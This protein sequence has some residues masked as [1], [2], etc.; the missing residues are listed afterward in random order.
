VNRVGPLLVAG[1]FLVAACQGARK[2]AFEVVL[3]PADAGP[4]GPDV[5][6]DP[7]RPEA[8]E[9]PPPD[10]SLDAPAEANPPANC[11]RRTAVTEDV[12]QNTA[13]ACGIYELTKKVWVHAGATLTIEAGSTIVADPIAADLP[14]LFVARGA[15]LIA[16]GTSR[17][18][19]VFTSGKPAG[20]RMPGDWA[21]VVLFGA[22]AI[23]SGSTCPG[24]AAG[25]RETALAGF[26]ASEA[27][28]Y[29]GGQDDAGS[30]GELEFVRIEFAGG[31]VSPG[32]FLNALT[33]AGC[34][35][36]TRISH[37][38]IH[39]GRDDGIE[40]LGGT[41]GLDHVVVS[42]VAD[43]ALDWNMGWRGTAQF[44]VVHHH[45]P[46]SD[47]AFEGSN[48]INDESAEPRSAPKIANV[49]M[50]S[51]ISNGGGNRALTFKEG[52]RGKL[53]NMVIQGF[54]RDVV[55]FVSAATNLTAEWP[56]NLSI[57][58]SFFWNNGPYLNDPMGDDDMSFPDQ[59]AVEDPARKN[60]NDV[61][62][63]IVITD[64]TTP[65]FVPSN[66]S[67]GNVPAPDFG[68]TTAA[69]AGAFRPR[70]PSPWTAGWTAYP[71]N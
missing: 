12:A 36:A 62:P 11:A 21:G 61:D 43:D 56:A 7:P 40:M 46:R 15:R 6:N 52:T 4:A 27:R 26:P 66:E 59:M 29:F 49:T 35:A 24:G 2:H 5:A 32:T 58:R 19:I 31:E 8:S 51:T 41:A 25:C 70:D 17:Q 64:P 67:L 69:F 20:A 18:P 55:N 9:P 22:A 44:L 23:N 33:V 57:E 16:R 34:G 10:A 47:N 48:K 45:D 30:C 53:R 63:G 71:A 14:G 65:N 54:K 3:G 1:C 60:H 50:T 37:T 13:W 38:Q 42:A 28:G 68:D 39:R